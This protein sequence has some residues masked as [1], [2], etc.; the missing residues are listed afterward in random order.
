MFTTKFSGAMGLGLQHVAGAVWVFV[1]GVPSTAPLD[2]R[3]SGTGGGPPSVADPMFQ[4]VMVLCSMVWKVTGNAGHAD[5][6]QEA[7]DV[8]GGQVLRAVS[9]GLISPTSWPSG[10]ETMAYRA[11]QKASKGHWRPT[12]PA[13]VSA[14]WR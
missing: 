8:T 11:P 12:Y 3:A 9:R 4:W 6:D 2:L 10:S 14:A 5:A 13:A 1:T 7:G